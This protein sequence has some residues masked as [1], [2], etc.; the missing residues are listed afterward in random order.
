MD[1]ITIVDKV[2]IVRLRMPWNKVDTEWLASEE[3][4]ENYG[5]E[6]EIL[7]IYVRARRKDSPN[8]KPEL[9]LSPASRRAFEAAPD[10]YEVIETSYLLAWK[11][12][13]E[14]REMLLR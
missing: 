10:G 8:D 3:D 2:L 5:D 14:T 7:E 12:S 1:K 9:L 13:P 11:M 4:L 6:V